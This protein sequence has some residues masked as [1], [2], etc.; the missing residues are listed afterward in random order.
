MAKRFHLD[1]PADDVAR[2][3]EASGDLRIY[4][5]IDPGYEGAV[6]V[7]VPDAPQIPAVIY[8]LPV[9]K[10][11]VPSTR[12]GKKIK[13]VRAEYNYPLINA[14]F[15]PLLDAMDRVHIC[16]EKGQPMVRTPKVCRMC[17]RGF[18]DTAK[19]GYAVGISYGMWLLYFAAVGLPYVDVAPATW[20]RATE[21]LGKD[22]QAA[23]AKVLRLR[24]NDSHFLSA[25]SDHN[26][27]EAMLLALYLHQ[28]HTR[29]AAGLPVEPEK[30]EDT[31]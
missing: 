24:P 26:R 21:M 20:K 2:L 10:L 30:T 11:T 27:A 18:G 25:K 15:V 23:I 1:D 13:S 31:E 16:L 29:E 6:A 7:C 9:L 8:D 4:V 12:K 14:Y 17:K 3:V 22:K 5:G 19:T 28:K